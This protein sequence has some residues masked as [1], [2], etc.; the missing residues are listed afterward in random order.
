MKGVLEEFRKE[1]FKELERLNKIGIVPWRDFDIKTLDS[2]LYDEL[3]K[4]WEF[5]L[6]Y[7]YATSEEEEEKAKKGMLRK[8]IDIA[9]HCLFLWVRIKE[10]IDDA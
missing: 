10:E 4:Y 6:D 8:L 7:Y 2:D 3:D 1:M 5:F 9:N